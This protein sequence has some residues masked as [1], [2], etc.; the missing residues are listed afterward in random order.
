MCEFCYEKRVLSAKVSSK[1]F[2]FVL[3]FRS[4]VR[5][6]GAVGPVPQAKPLHAFA[7]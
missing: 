3:F 4:G 2:V 6:E 1:R 5:G 7:V